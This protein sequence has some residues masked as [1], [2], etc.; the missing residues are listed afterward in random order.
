MASAS[1][2]ESGLSAIFSGAD[3]IFQTVNS[4]LEKNEGRLIGRHGTIELE[5]LLDT[6]HPDRFCPTLERNAG[7]FPR[8][9]DSLFE[10]RDRYTA[11]VREADGMAV[12]W[13]APLA[14]KEAEFLNTVNPDAERF[15][16]RSL[17]PYYCIN[18]PWTRVLKGRRVAVVS[19]FALSMDEQ[20]L[21]KDD[22]W[23]GRPEL[24]P[25][26]DWHFIRSYYSPDLAQGRAGWPKGIASWSDAVSYLETEVLKTGA[27]VVLIGCGGLAMPLALALKRRGLV[28]IVLGGA[29]QVLF[30]IKGRRWETHEVISKFWNDDWIYPKPEE[31]PQGARDIEGGCYW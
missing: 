16:L 8:T 20:L 30:G 11:A 21:F 27:R 23:K 5:T 10:W 7:I 26:A 1:Q 22:I 17:E 28:A 15:P 12:G 13:Y 19:S 4:A 29:I 18:Q 25:D 31:T 2:T 24:L 14:A 9:R 3:W 6:Q